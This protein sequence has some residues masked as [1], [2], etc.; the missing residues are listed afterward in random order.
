MNERIK[1]LAKQAGF[2]MEI[3]DD[4]NSPPGWWGAGHNPT[5][6]KFAELI[7]AKC[8][9]IADD[10]SDNDIIPTKIN[11]YFGVER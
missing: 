6:E 10:Y 11:K 4:P 9:E 3:D 2:A 5:F 8:V 1:E 7:I